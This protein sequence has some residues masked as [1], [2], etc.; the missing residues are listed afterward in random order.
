MRPVKEVAHPRWYIDAGHLEIETAHAVACA[1]GDFEEVAADRRDAAGVA[2]AHGLW[3]DP[4][5]RLMRA[6][7]DE[8]FRA[9]MRVVTA[10]NAGPAQI[11]R[12]VAA[13]VGGER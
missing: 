6:V 12:F 1:I 3:A 10:A 4:D 7:L 13:W 2:L 9:A 5:G 8:D 11:V